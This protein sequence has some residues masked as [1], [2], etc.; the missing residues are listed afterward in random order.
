MDSPS[1]ASLLWVIR[2]T[3][4]AVADAGRTPACV[5]HA[6][7][8][9]LPKLR[10]ILAAMIA[11]CAAV[12]TLSA[13]MLGTRDQARNISGVPDINRPLMRQAA[14]EEPEGQQLQLLAY[15]RRADELMRLRNLPVTPVRAVV[16]YAEQA[17]ARA[18]ESATASAAS[19]TAAAPAAPASE[20]APTIVATAPMATPADA[21]S[22]PVADNA[23]VVVTPS[24]D[25]PPPATVAVAPL[26]NPPTDTSAATPVASPTVATPPA[27]T[28]PETAVA[29]APVAVPAA[30]T[31]PATAIVSAPASL[32]AVET[33][34][35]A[36]AETAPAAVAD[37]APAAAA[38]AVPPATNG[39]TQVATV[40]T[41]GSETA[42]RH[43]P[44]KPKAAP[45]KRHAPKAA[46]AHTTK[47]KKKTQVARTIRSVAPSATT[48]FPVDQNSRSSTF[49][50][51]RP[52]G[53]S[54]PR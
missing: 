41:G 48:R 8:I 30:D 32:P 7:K 47:P 29:I 21:P 16:E 20:P 49:S 34:V 44:E 19:T 27:D 45:K 50:N 23:A 6:A 46:H 33:P 24:A 9:M 31:T 3:T 51:W 52:S 10:I 38:P 17:Q 28:L 15:S 26:A 25:T 12:L 18:A 39:D 5:I 22:V 2:T 35:A 43:G 54:T 53:E 40:Q 11:T 13:G 4:G 36:P 14:V 42:E 1:A 37:A